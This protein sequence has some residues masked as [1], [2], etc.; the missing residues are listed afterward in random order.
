[1]SPVADP[2][3]RLVHAVPHRGLGNTS[4][5]V[6]L[7]DGRALVVDPP[8]DPRALRRAAGERGLAIAYAAD[9][10]LHA[11]FLSG[12]VQL[13]HTEGARLLA[14]AAGRREFRH[15]ALEDG[16]E[17][18]LGGLVLRALATP[19]HTDE[20][21][22][23]LLLDG[24]RELGVFSGG[25]LLVGSAA[26]T[27][28]VDPDRTEELARAQFR[29]LRRL[30]LL[31]PDTRLWPTHGGGS[32]CSASG[33]APGSDSTIAAEVATNPLL[34]AVDEDEF[35]RLLRGVTGSRPPYYDD[36]PALNRRGPTVVAEP[37]ALSALH[38]VQVAA[39]VED[40]AELVDVRPV[41]AFAAG[42]PS[43]ALSIA[44][45][46]GFTSWLGWLV[47]DAER[48]V[49]VLRDERQDPADLVW[50]ALETGRRLAGEVA[51]GIDAW[52]AAGL[53]V[54]GLPLVDAEQLDDTRLLDVRQAAELT[55]LSVPGAE[56]VEL[57]AVAARASDLAGVP[58][59]VLC[60]HGERATTAA[61]LLLRAGARDVRV[62]AGSA[63]DAARARS[64]QARPEP[65]PSTHAQPDPAQSQRLGSRV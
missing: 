55:G 51:G 57:G 12:A 30:A 17:V 4:W 39:L 9:T 5:L 21:L 2:D 15:C 56:H 45:R 53:P 19:G 63:A 8:R 44:W 47:R 62:L 27:D 1:M 49:V 7:G 48:P 46:P 20:H 14:S 3:T 33:T 24:E 60:G 6:D 40:G 34:R 32:F 65:A 50:A 43:G 42:H 25:S 22:S 23:F 58:T 52:R 11:D 59:T 29:S 61:S 64:R 31:A 41:E 16:D 10:H 54:T 38:P 35:V 28:L 18:D 13:A 37:V 26:R 36:L